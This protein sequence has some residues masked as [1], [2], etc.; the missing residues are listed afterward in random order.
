MGEQPQLRRRLEILK[1]DEK[2]PNGPRVKPGRNESI[3]HEGGLCSIELPD[4]S[5]PFYRFG[6]GTL[7]RCDQRPTGVWL[8]GG[9][10][11]AVVRRHILKKPD[12]VALISS[13]DAKDLEKFEGMVGNGSASTWSN[14]Q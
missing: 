11:D 13:I 10:P 6:N 4:G 9:R 3:V 5:L 8:G 7:L 12:T 14:K 2:A 1:K